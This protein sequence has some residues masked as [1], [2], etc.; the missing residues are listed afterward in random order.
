MRQYSPGVRRSAFALVGDLA[1]AC[2]SA[3]APALPQVLE[4]SA[5]NLEAKNVTAANMSACNNACWAAGELALAA[6]PVGTRCRLN[7]SG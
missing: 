4:L 1:R 6:P 3:V 5:A 7:T 2:F